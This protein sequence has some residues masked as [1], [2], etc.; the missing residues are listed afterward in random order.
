MLGGSIRLGKTSFNKH[1]GEIKNENH[2]RL[3]RQVLTN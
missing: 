1:G 2:L 3:S